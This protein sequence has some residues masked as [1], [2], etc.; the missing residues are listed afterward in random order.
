MNAPVKAKEQ[1]KAFQLHLLRKLH[2]K[3]AL[4]VHFKSSIEHPHY[5]HCTCTKTSSKTQKFYQQG[6][7]ICIVK[8]K[9]LLIF[10]NLPQ[11]K[12]Q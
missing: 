11:Q 12:I 7:R 10:L 8:K 5:K 3:T 2:C 1:R 4:S 6:Q 9:S